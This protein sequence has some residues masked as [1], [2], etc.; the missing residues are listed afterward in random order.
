[1]RTPATAP[2]DLAATPPHVGLAGVSNHLLARVLSTGTPPAGPIL[3]RV[4]HYKGKEVPTEAN[5]PRIHG[6][7]DADLQKLAKDKHDY[8]TITDAASV[9]AAMVVYTTNNTVVQAP[10]PLDET[11]K[12]NKTVWDAPEFANYLGQ[13]VRATFQLD[14][15]QGKH[16]DGFAAADK[17]AR[18]ES[19]GQKM[20]PGTDYESLAQGVPAALAT[21]R[22]TQ[23]FANPARVKFDFSVQKK[24]Q[25]D[26]LQYEISAMWAPLAAGRHLLVFYHCYPPR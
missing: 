7:K 9:A 15:G 13:S 18:K 1:L 20:P 14:A 3:Q 4:F 6:V 16:D 2:L 11:Y 25:A 26:G 19:G 21:A 12:G 5:V 24:V 17:D 10:P 8:G 22:L 23:I